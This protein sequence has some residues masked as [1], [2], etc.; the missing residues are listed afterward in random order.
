MSD[1]TRFCLTLDLENDWYFDEP[2]YDHLIFNHIDEFIG[3]I[4][5]LDVPL[6]IFAVG[7]TIEKYPEHVNRLARELDCEFHLHSYQHDTEKR[8]D[9]R[10]EVQRGKAAF[11]NHFGHTPIGYRAPQGN[12]KPGE[13][14]I[15]EEEG[16]V[17]DSSI[18]PSYRP[19]V[20]SNLDSPLKPYYPKDT[21]LLEIPLGVIRGIRVPVSQ[22][23]F[24]LFGRPLSFLLSTAP[25]STPLIYNIHMHDF[26]HTASHENLNRVKK[27]VHNRNIENST[28]ILKSN[29]KKIKQRGFEPVLIS[30]LVGDY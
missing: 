13:I 28:N 26:Y 27:A 19:G 25:L 12:I 14:E 7:K 9:F 18:F 22:S 10:N 30:E 16:F 6:S 23:Y 21:S 17:F 11:K 8:Y 24:K 29:I 3:T 20:Y 5:N 1:D 2:G 4:Q 15:L